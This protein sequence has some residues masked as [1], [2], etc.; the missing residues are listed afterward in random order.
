M[1]LPSRRLS[2]ANLL[3]VHVVAARV[4]AGVVLCLGMAGVWGWAVIQSELTPAHA[5]TQ[6]PQPPP[7][8]CA[9]PG[10]STQV[11][12]S[13]YYWVASDVETTLLL[14]NKSPQPL[15][16][17]P[18]LFGLDGQ[19]HSAPPLTIAGQSFR[20]VPLAELGARE[21]TAFGSGSVALAFEGAPLVLGAQVEMKDRRGRL[22][23]DRLSDARVS[24]ATTWLAG[25]YR[26]PRGG[27]LKVAVTNVTERP[28]GVQVR[29]DGKGGK[30][31]RF[32]L[33]GRATRLVDVGLALGEVPRSGGVVVE[34]DERGA[35]RANGWVWNA[36]GYVSV[37]SFM[38]LGRARDGVWHANGVRVRPLVKGKLT[39]YVTVHNFGARES[40]VRGWLVGRVGEAMARRELETV[41]LGAGETRTLAVVLSEEERRGMQIAGI[42]LAYGSGAGTIGAAV[43][44]EREDGA[45]GYRV[46]V[47]DREMI[48]SATG[49]YPVRL[50]MDEN[51]VVYLKNTTDKEVRYHAS[52]RFESGED[53]GFGQAKLGPGET[54]MIDLGRARLMGQPDAR[55]ERMPF[56]ER[57]QFFWSV[58]GVETKGIVGRAEYLD[59]RTEAS[60]TYACYNC[61]G[62]LFGSGWI[63]GPGALG[64]TQVRPYRAFEQYLTCY[65]G[66]HVPQL[67]WVQ[68]WEYSS[69]NGAGAVVQPGQSEAEVSGNHI[70][71]MALLARWTAYDCNLGSF[72]H[73]AWFP[74]QVKPLVILHRVGPFNPATITADNI[75]HISEC[76][77]VIEVHGFTENLT[78]LNVRFLIY[79]QEMT[80][81]G[82]IIVQP[83]ER[84]VTVFASDPTKIEKVEF[85]A[86]FDP[87]M[88]DVVTVRGQVRIL[89]RPDD[90]VIEPPDVRV[91]TE[92]LTVNKP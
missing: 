84:K 40:E 79:P 5:Q 73:T 44:V 63:T 15:T 11:L 58:Q 90:Y 67:A 83:V 45:R 1:T 85:K 46:P 50:G 26:L 3:A 36:A 82:R 16:V 12:T 28:V 86:Q 68:T 56:H 33:G 61:C 65:G 53:Y 75:N 30:G 34:S 92:L 81:F 2:V 66:L 22:V 41:R 23:S 6:A 10:G 31:V 71:E 57:G 91:S 32:E 42:E 60:S 21:G 18:T 48:P 88:T 76:D 35:V 13:S 17:Q 9:M 25:V 47:V 69:A 64:V 74:V 78:S 80:G 29:V 89:P 62:D 87:N 77:V 20:V 70:G 38:D 8:G 55:G 24:L 14:N 19:R 59:Y 49:S 27:A 39:P 54:V 72:L 51:T 7:T 43:D 4:A 52:V 37:V